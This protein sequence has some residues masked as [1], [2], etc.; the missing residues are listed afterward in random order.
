MSALVWLLLLQT[1]TDL[2]RSLA[3]RFIMKRITGIVVLAIGSILF[4]TAVS[5]GGA[6]L[7]IVRAGKPV[8]AIVVAKD[9][10]PQVKEAAK[11]LSAFIEQSTGAK[12][13]IGESP[14]ESQVAIYVGKSPQV[15]S[16]KIDQSKIN[17]DDGF[18]IAFPVKNVVVVLGKSDHG[19]DFGVH[20]FL[21]RYVG[22][23]WLM[24]GPFGTDVPKKKT[25]AIPMEPVRQIPSFSSRQLVTE[26]RI[27]DYPAG[28]A[29]AWARHNRS[30]TR[31]AG[32]AHWL[33]RLFSVADAKAHPEFFPL[34][35]DGK[36]YQP[37]GPQGWQPCMDPA[38][39]AET[40]IQRITTFFDRTPTA[41]SY[42]LSV[43]DNGNYCRCPHCEAK[44][45]DSNYSNLYYPWVN[46]VVEG[47][48]K[49]HPDKLF[50]LL[51]YNNVALPP[52]GKVH[53]NVVPFMTDDRMK[54]AHPKLRE[55]G[56]ELTRQ[57][58]KKCPTLAWYDYLYG[59]FYLLPRVYPHQMAETLRFGHK[60]GVR[61]YYAET[62]PH[63]GEG[64]KLYVSLKLLWN[65]DSDVD[66]LL[67]G[68]CDRVGGKEAGPFLRQY[69]AFWEEFWTRRVIKSSWVRHDM[70]YLPIFSEPGYLL[71]VTEKELALCR[72]QMETAL[73]KAKT[74]EQ[75]DRVRTLYDAFEFYEASALA[76]Q[77]GTPL[78]IADQKD[79]LACFDRAARALEMGKK[80]H[81]LATVIFPSNPVLAMNSGSGMLRF[82]MDRGVFDQLASAY[83]WAAKNREKAEP[84][85]ERF[86][87]LET[88]ADSELA[89]LAKLARIIASDPKKLIERVQNGSFEDTD[90]PKEPITP[91]AGWKTTNTPPHWYKWVA[92]Y[93]SG[94][95]VR[96]IETKGHSGKRS[97]KI[98]G[99]HAA[100]LQKIPV[101]AG[102]AYIAS[103]H[104][105]GRIVELT[106]SAKMVI[107]WMDGKGKWMFS[108]QPSA[109][110][111]LQP[112]EATDGW[113]KR[114]STMIRVPEGAA[115]L[116]VNAGFHS[117]DRE[118]YLF[119][120]DISVKQ[121]IMD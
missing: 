88:R 105:N 89:D 19:T 21:E 47:V 30:Q 37:T 34:S 32:Q 25:L 110:L 101:K 62:S 99:G 96:W 86:R 82:P 102:E 104:L 100:L 4:V 121:V 76:Y 120:D 7:D 8:A 68:W 22:V 45:R 51:A 44:L 41:Q 36:R 39:T 3:R 52:T 75:K 5:V 33:N 48:T 92:D 29:R 69:Y 17:D 81:R 77:A 115:F 84:V 94:A 49:K 26:Y 83:A 23:R 42:A 31:L 53:P 67:D 1:A 108:S 103:V 56:E 13:P 20:E 60:N 63:F 11:L 118:D 43:N 74:Q 87:E 57:W 65:V 97:I 116:V 90:A 16:F 2:N 72:K 18:D 117:S 15:T 61:H 70:T 24:P 64:P 95:E 114:S 91:G 46:K 38:V 73:A 12:L 14:P 98:S 109:T 66:A 35:K 106:G 111:E 6:P 27:G 79:A 54:W 112:G 10:S 93:T 58:H 85:F 119:I 50:G 107:Q 40:A 55:R 71:Q 80:R 78:V 59:S 28:W 9:V 113:V